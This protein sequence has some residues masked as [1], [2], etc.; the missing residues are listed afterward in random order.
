M[1]ETERE[2]DTIGRALN[3]KCPAQNLKTFRYAGLEE[4]AATIRFQYPKT[5]FM[6]VLNMDALDAEGFPIINVRKLGNTPLIATYATSYTPRGRI[7]NQ[8]VTD[9]RLEFLTAFCMGKA[10]VVKVKTSMFKSHG[11]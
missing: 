6:T 5:A 9:T 1:N 3:P 4:L 7:L 11:E 8:R 10:G 2:R